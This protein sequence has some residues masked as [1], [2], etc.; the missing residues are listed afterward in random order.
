M[1]LP[2]S[3]PE[4]GHLRSG[5]SASRGFLFLFSS[6]FAVVLGLGMGFVYHNYLTFVPDG[7]AFW[8]QDLSGMNRLHAEQVVGTMV[9]DW[10]HEQVVLEVQRADD[11]ATK[12]LQVSELGF[13]YDVPATVAAMI[14]G[15]YIQADLLHGSA[16]KSATKPV[17]EVQEGVVEQ[18]LDQVVSY[19]SQPMNAQIVLDESTQNWKL[20]QD[21]EGYGFDAEH[22]L[23]LARE[24]QA[25]AENGL[26]SEGGI[27]LE[28]ETLYPEVSG[29]DLMPL[30]RE[31]RYWLRKSVSWNEEGVL[32]TLFLKENPWLIDVDVENKTVTLSEPALEKYVAE[33]AEAFDREKTKVQVS[34]PVQQEGDYL[35]SA[36]NGD[37][38]GGRTLQQETMVSALKEALTSQEQVTEIDL[39]FDSD[40]T[41]LEL[42]DGTEL[43][44]LSQGQSSYKE[45]NG[46][47]RVFN[48]KFGLSKYNGVVIPQGAEFSFNQVLGWVTYDAGWRP[49]LAIFG[50]GGVK[51]VPGGG[52]C[53][54]ST[55]F[56]RSVINGG[57]PVTQRKPHSL[58]VSYYHAYGYGIDSTIYPP[59][60]IDLKFVNDTPGPIVVRTYV[61]E[62]AEEAFV[63]FYGI[64]DGR[65]V[66]L[67]Q[68]V[69]RPVNLPSEVI[70]TT[71]LPEGVKEVTKP[72][73][74][75]Y[76]EWDWK[77]T[78]A[79]G[80]VDHRTIETLYPARRQTVR[81]GV[82]E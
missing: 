74:G 38:V 66:E 25:L 41:V 27:L 71:D 22:Q 44:Y 42:W 32:Q 15:E 31:L 7:T 80:T 62:V 52:L 5:S 20:E 49:A 17:V 35:K 24:I 55:T 57:M 77:V 45:G 50:G 10:Q 43:T 69:N 51:P 53:Q 75:R 81:V 30:Y 78:Q 33:Y 65:S 28:L 9:S 61:D 68:T 8:G 73:T 23:I 6:V 58:D 54:V 13:D 59:E 79:D 34:E 26:S 19:E 11:I 47:D 12:N 40:S 48:V 3:L 64:D 1:D 4:K 2:Q 60:D 29:E 67:E 21:Q 72:R 46:E 82:A 36:F 18:L 56:Y 63:E 39:P 37:F 76:I 16:P 70:Y 14:A